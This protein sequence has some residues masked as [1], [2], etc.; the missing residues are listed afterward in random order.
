MPNTTG[1]P[2]GDNL[3]IV[4]WDHDLGQ[5][6]PM[7]RAT[8]SEDGSYLITDVGSGLT[9]AGWGGLCIYDPDKC[10]KNAP[11]KCTECQIVDANA[12]CPTCKWDAAKDGVLVDSDTWALSTEPFRQALE[13]LTISLPVGKITPKFL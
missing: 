5:F 9:K 4:Q 13:L 7:G 10:A 1:Q 12:D 2:P 6:V 8:V 11:P 3:P